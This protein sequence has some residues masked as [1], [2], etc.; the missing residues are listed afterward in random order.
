MIDSVYKPGREFEKFMNT[1]PYKRFLKNDPSPLD[2]Q[3]LN[4]SQ[5]ECLWGSEE[6]KEASIRW[7]DPNRQLLI[8]DHASL[9][10][11]FILA[12]DW[13]Y[14]KKDADK[15][16]RNIRSLLKDVKV[17]RIKGIFDQLSDYVRLV[18][19]EIERDEK[20]LSSK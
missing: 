7:Q 14:I 4:K 10:Y 6:S 16:E 11:N 2:I 12:I 19:S 9:I 15:A 18:L 13:V 1:F 3:K 5:S 8:D 20:F 17:M